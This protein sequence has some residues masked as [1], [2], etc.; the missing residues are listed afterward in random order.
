M[1]SH[2]HARTR[3][4]G[5]A[6]SLAA[7]LALALVV[8]LV[9]PG[10]ALTATTKRVSMNSSEGQGNGASY[11][12]RVSATGRF[13]VFYASATNL[14]GGDTN[15][16]TDVFVRDRKNGTTR[17]VSKSSAG[18]QANGGSADP[19]I[20]S[21]GRFVG[22]YSSASN[23]VGGDTNGVPDVFVHDRNT[24][25][26]RRVSVSSQEG[27]GNGE[28]GN[29]SLS[30]DGRFV[31][32]YSLA[33]NLVG[34]DTNGYQDIF[35]RDR[36]NGTTRRVSVSSA[37][38]QA[39]GDSSDPSIS[40]DGS[41][42]AFSSGAP[43]LVGADTN[44]VTDV[45]V[46]NRVA[47]TTQRVSVS[48]AGVQ[49]N[50]GSRGPAI[51]GGGRFVAFHS[52]AA[53]LVG[54]DT[55]GVLDVF[56]RDRRN[57]VTKR[58]SVSSGGVQADGHSDDASISAD[59]R[60]VAFDSSATNLVGNDTNAKD[61]VFLRNRSTARTRLVSRN[62]AGFQG[63]ERSYVPWISADGRFVVFNSAAT[64]M[65]LNDTNGFE[66]V[67]IRGPLR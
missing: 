66:D 7:L 4:P 62:S 10:L 28:S 47:G 20:S 11:S 23:L 17:R 3:L 32:F 45:F 64:N 60:M 44:A 1:Q 61:D 65:V 31:A 5:S 57:H 14:V 26:M 50:G 59:G 63:N 40:A 46:R 30:A 12:P 18:A 21:N 6:L 43:D 34:G 13:V 8:E 67:F 48:S 39:S 35:V 51:S 36:K 15:G 58:V 2:T 37:E 52:S 27:Q 29:L 55:N 9:P 22:F 54:N 33:S 19:V 41:L 24:G 53:N 42:V 49:A 38:I 16:V 56:L 25:S